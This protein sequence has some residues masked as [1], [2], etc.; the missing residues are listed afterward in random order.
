ML[1][2]RCC[3]DLLDQLVA[4]LLGARRPD[5]GLYVFLLFGRRKH[6][7]QA[8]TRNEIAPGTSPC[9]GKDAVFLV[10]DLLD[11][12]SITFFSSPLADFP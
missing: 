10:L 8:E 7:L 12:R 1:F 3:P 5:C 4:R 9:C 11:C 6:G 2:V